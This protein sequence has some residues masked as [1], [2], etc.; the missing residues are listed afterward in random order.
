MG[1]YLALA[2]ENPMT[3]RIVDVAIH[4]VGTAEI[5]PDVYYDVKGAERTARDDE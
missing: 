4:R 5:R 1:S 2:K 3:R